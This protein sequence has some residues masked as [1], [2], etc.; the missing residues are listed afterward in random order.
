MS[1]V[2]IR[3][4]HNALYQI[5][6]APGVRAELERRGRRIVANA[7][8]TLRE[9]DGYAMSSTQ[10]ARRPQGRW[11]VTVFTRST[12]AKRSNARHNTL[13]RLMQS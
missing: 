9:R 6:S 12:H 4:N 11:R 8:S 5:R 10:G 13:V 2:K 7:N 3:W 1:E